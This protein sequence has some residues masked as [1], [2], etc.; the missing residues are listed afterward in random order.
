MRYLY[1]F[2]FLILLSVPAIALPND[3]DYD[4]DAIF[5]PVD[6]VLSAT[7]SI[8]VTNNSDSVFDQLYFHL[9][10]NAFSRDSLSQYKQ[11]LLEHMSP[12]A[13][14]NL[15]ADPN[16]DA[17]IEILSIQ[18]GGQ[19]LEFFENDTLLTVD[20]L[21]FLR[22][23]ERVEIQIAYIYNL[24]EGTASDLMA[25]NHAVRS[26]HRE[27]VYTMTLWYPKLAVF[28]FNGWFLEPY[29]YF[30]EF[31][32]DFASYDVQI[33]LPRAYEVGATGQLALEAI[34]G[35]SKTLLFNAENVHDFAWVASDRYQTALA[36]V[37]G[38]AINSLYVDDERSGQI[39]LAAEALQYFNEKYG[40]YP[41]ETFT[42]AQV[43]VGGG[44]EYPALIAIGRGTDSEIVHEVAHQW[45]Y[46]AIGNNEMSETWLDEGFTTFAEELFFIEH[47]GQSE[48]FVRSSRSFSETGEI[49]LQ[50]APNFSSLSNFG[51]AV[52]TKGSGILWM[53]RSYLGAEIFDDMLKAYFHEFSLRNVTTNDFVEFASTYAHEDLTWFFDQWLRTTA[54]LDF[55]IADVSTRV[56]EDG[57]SEHVV[58]VENSGDARMPVT[59]QVFPSDSMLDPFNV[60]WDGQSPSVEIV[61]DQIE[62][63][64]GLEIDPDREVLEENRTNN[65]WFSQL[66]GLLTGLASVGV[67]GILVV[68]LRGRLSRTD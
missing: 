48:Y 15:Y 26:A 11:D 13:L 63:I 33:T 27:G 57:V 38:I 45:W 53:L 51:S 64:S 36:E 49:V 62:G 23:G 25:F 16:D 56:N 44:M 28:D 54:S 1:G 24:M 30:G 67:L 50:P 2:I 40:P 43:K 59:I 39:E 41:Y 42:I 37:D 9:Y 4:I 29:R 22:P 6:N 34:E 7:A 20:L 12:G 61:I 52:Y 58:R 55:S 47:R 10:P 8:T 31:Y 21:D 60:V 19:S 17:F 14:V 32:G 35:D 68:G 3:V 46:G 65:A 5:N 18:S 66:A